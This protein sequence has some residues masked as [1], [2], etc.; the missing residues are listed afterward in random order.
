MNRSGRATPWL[1]GLLALAAAAVA[2]RTADSLREVLSPPP[3]ES[4]ASSLRDAGLDGSEVGRAWFAAAGRAL[5]EPPLARPPADEVLYFDPAAPTAAGWRLELRRGQRLTVAATPQPGLGG[6][7]FVDLFR[8]PD[9]GAAPAEPERAGWA[10]EGEPLEYAVRRDGAY[11]VR[12][13]PELL[14]GGRW[15]VRLR[16]EGSLTFPVE[17]ADASAIGST[18]GDPR[19]GGRRR[20]LGV[21]IFAPRGTLALAA[22]DGLV[23]AGTNELG[24]NVVWLYAAD[25]GLSFYYA[26]LD[27][28]LAR[29]GARVKAGEPVGR[30]GNT[31]NARATRPHL[32]FGIYAEGA[33]DPYPYLW[34]PAGGPPPLAV[35]ADA[36]GSLR[37]IA[38]RLV[39]LRGGPGT[40]TPIRR[41]ME[42]DTVV[43]VRGATAEW[44]RVGLPD[45]AAGYVAGR[46]TEPAERPLARVR[47]PDGGVLLARPEAAAPAVAALPPGGEVAVLGVFVGFRWVEAAGRRGWLP[48]ALLAG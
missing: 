12:L 38:G 10:E 48:A 45:G 41:E 23:R 11:L 32:H 1:L 47:A 43:E 6:R 3:W 39:R 13:Q 44:Y 26:H 36:L 18:F 20:H 14:A 37:R 24:G 19:D 29:T 8:A 22:T 2:C 40:D 31:G 25:L 33:V 27:R 35:D 42:G 16:V 21:D 46:L 5:A 7:L 9:P 15:T 34:R 4:Y 17:G 28:Q 30:V